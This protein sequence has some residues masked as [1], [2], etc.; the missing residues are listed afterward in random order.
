MTFFLPHSPKAESLLSWL[1]DST[2]LRVDRM[3]EGTMVDLRC[4]ESDHSIIVRRLIEAG[5][6]PS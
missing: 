4:R 3:P 2:E 5:G 6:R 1:H